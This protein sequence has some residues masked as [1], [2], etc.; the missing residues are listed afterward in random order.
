MNTL[1]IVITQY[2]EWLD[3]E[4]LLQ[5]TT[6]SDNRDHTQLVREFLDLLSSNQ[7]P[8]VAKDG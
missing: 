2:S 6:E 3:S 5:N 4:G 7:I 1:E 8:N